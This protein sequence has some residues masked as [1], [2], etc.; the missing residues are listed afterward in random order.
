VAW[1]L[2]VLAGLLEV[3]WALSLKA[4]DGFTRFVPSI[5]TLVTM[6]ASFYLLS[7]AVR[8]LPVGS[9]YPVWVGIGAAGTALFGMVVLGEPRSLVRILGIVMIVG[10]VLVLRA[11]DAL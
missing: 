6:G 4:T 10:G 9:A 3:V 8:T 7:Q 5:F 11:T 1:F 2:L